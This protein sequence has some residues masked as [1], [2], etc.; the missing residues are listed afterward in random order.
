M[1]C[2]VQAGIVVDL[3]C[4]VLLIVDELFKFFA[5]KVNFTEIQRPKISEEWLIHQIIVYAEVERV[6]A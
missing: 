5:E 2:V 1:L 4:A 6:R 3:V